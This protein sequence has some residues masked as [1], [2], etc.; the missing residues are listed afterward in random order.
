MAAGESG[1]GGDV[2]HFEQWVAGCL[3]PDGFGVGLEC[4]GDAV[5][6]GHIDKG[7][8]QSLFL[9]KSLEQPKRTTVEVC[10][11]DHVIPGR[12]EGHG[13]VDGGHA[14]GCGNTASTAFE[15]GDVFFE[16]LAGGVA[17]AG[18]VVP[19]VA[20]ERVPVEGG[21]GIDWRGDAVVL[22]ILVDAAVDAASFEVQWIGGFGGHDG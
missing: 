12:K 1:D 20:F 6:V 22:L 19:G 11:G 9:Q 7:E 10:W 3:D 4:G 15:C 21:G 8:L 5:D 17:G 18:V 2:D 14:G 16:G 13:A